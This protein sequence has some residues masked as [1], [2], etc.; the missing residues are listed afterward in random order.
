M[1]IGKTISVLVA[2]GPS[3]RLRPLKFRWSGRLVDVKEITYRWITKEGQSHIYHF[4]ITD[5]DTLYEL[6]FNTNSLL[7][8]LENLE[9]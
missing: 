2:F 8:R 7:W 1:H 9:S 5:G 4:S 3:Y 6:S